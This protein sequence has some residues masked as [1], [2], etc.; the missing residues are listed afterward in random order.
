MTLIKSNLIYFSLV[1]CVF[2]SYLRDHCLVLGNDDLRLC[3]FP[4]SFIVLVL[5]FWSWIHFEFTLHTE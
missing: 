1:S 2:V 3:F 5:T 4:K